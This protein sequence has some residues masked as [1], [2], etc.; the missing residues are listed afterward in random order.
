MGS[1]IF[2]VW[3]LVITKHCSAQL[4]YSTWKRLI[5]ESIFMGN[6][7]LC[8]LLPQ[9]MTIMCINH[10]TSA[11]YVVNNVCYFWTVWCKVCAAAEICSF[12]MFSN[13]H[14]FCV[15]IPFL[16]GWI[17]RYHQRIEE[18]IRV[19]IILEA[20]KKVSSMLCSE[21]NGQSQPWI[22]PTT[23]LFAAKTLKVRAHTH[24]T[25][26]LKGLTAS[27]RLGLKITVS[28]CL[29]QCVIVCP[30]AESQTFTSIFSSF[31]FH[32]CVWEQRTKICTEVRCLLKK[33]RVCAPVCVCVCACAVEER[34]WLCV[35]GN[36]VGWGL[37]GL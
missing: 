14:C 16:L 20:H 21:F 4:W 18:I 36:G 26:Y 25:E 13:P 27:H 35:Y 11:N 6:R 29:H 23:K 3:S 12:C 31:Y 8:S 1:N 19:P 5:C 30:H 22:I 24:K 37:W 9:A 7:H 33:R 10:R 2:K 34:V 17:S 15:F 28:S 32:L